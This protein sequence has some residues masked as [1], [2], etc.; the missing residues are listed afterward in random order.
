MTDLKVISFMALEREVGRYKPDYVISVTDADDPNEKLAK[1]ILD[2]SGVPYHWM[3]FHDIDRVIDGYIAPSMPAIQGLIS[4]MSLTFAA[5]PE[6]ILVHCTAGI[7]RSPAV[8]MIALAH[9]SAMQ[10]VTGA[11]AGRDIVRKTFK[12]HPWIDPNARVMAIARSI[13]DDGMGAAMAHEVKVQM[14]CTPNDTPNPG[15][16]W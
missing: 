6:R 13:F 3:G 2:K 12:D 9:F 8:G 4:R 1:D 15:L 7:S 10:G 16:I 5:P 14:A 11:E